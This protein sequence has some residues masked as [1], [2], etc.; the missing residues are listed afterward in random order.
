MVDKTD[1]AD[2]EAGISPSGVIRKD[3][4][5][6]AAVS[7]T[8][9][10]LTNGLYVLTLSAGETNADIIALRFHDSGA[11][12]AQQVLVERTDSI[13]VATTLIQ[14]H[15]DNGTYGLDALETVASAI[16]IDTGT[17]LDALI[18][19]ID[20]NVDLVLTDTGTTLDNMI[21]SIL[22]TTASVLVDTKTTLDDKIDSILS[23]TT[24]VLVDTKTTLD[25]KIDS[26]LADTTSILIDSTSILVDTTS[27]LVDTKEINSQCDSILA[28]TGTTL[29]NKIDSIL[30]DTKTTLDN[31]IDSILVDTTSILVDSTSILV[32]TKTTLPETLSLFEST[33]DSAIDG[34]ITSILVDTG[35]T[36]D[37]RIPAALSGGNIKADALAI[38]TSTD[39]AD[40]LE[41]NA[42]AIVLGTVSWDNTNATTVV[43]YSNDA[44]NAVADH[45]TGRIVIFTS[46]ILTQQ[47]T[48]ITAYEQVAGE[49]KFTV[50]ALTSEP[51]DNV[52]FVIV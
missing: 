35:T 30:E 32:D 11:S 1:F 2:P 49:G 48:D 13:E 41:A 14:S 51:A 17:T 5:A 47:A 40:K 37:G 50:T 6:S 4:G 22:S 31:K 33:L 9:S 12:C 29:D 43:F 34:P 8:V 26:I 16:L 46:G 52:T 42:E 3:G 18:K 36:L 45:Y 10:E 38:S 25:D 27:M 21:E 19:T 7:N 24:S 23:T 39:A 44:A 28:D 15:L 20:S